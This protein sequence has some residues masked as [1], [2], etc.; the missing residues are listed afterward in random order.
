[1]I[2]ASQRMINEQHNSSIVNSYLELEIKTL[3]TAPQ[4]PDKLERLL[5]IKGR[6]NEE[7]QCTWRTHKG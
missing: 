3:Q 6:Q 2:E 4:D 7:E 5:K 1:M